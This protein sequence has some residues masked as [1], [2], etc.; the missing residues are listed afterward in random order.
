MFL[1]KGVSMNLI[2][3]T[4]NSKLNPINSTQVVANRLYIQYFTVYL[5]TVYSRMLALENTYITDPVNAFYNYQ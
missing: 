3:H 2:L 5:C 1:Q 4:S